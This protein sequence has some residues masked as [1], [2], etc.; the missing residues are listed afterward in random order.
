MRAAAVRLQEGAAG[1]FIARVGGDEFTL[2]VTTGRQPETAV[3]L[4]ERLVAAFQ[5]EFEVDGHRMQVGMS[6]GV[7]IYPADGEDA[8]TLLANADAALYQAKAEM[9]GSVRLFEIELGTRL[10]E[11]REMQNDLRV[12]IQRNQLALHYQPQ[13]RIASNEP[14]GFEALVRWHCPKRGTVSPGTFIPIAEDSGLIIPL[15]EWILR[16]ACEEAAAWPHPLKIAVNISPVQFHRGD[17]A[18]L[19]HEILMETGLS[20][21]RLELEITEGVMIDDFSR[22]VSILHRLKAIG[23]QIAMD[24]FGSGYS[25][26]SYLHA[27]PF[28]KIKI[29]R[30]FI[31]DLEHNHHSM[32]IV[33]AIIPLGHSMAVPILAEGVETEAQREFLLQ[34]GCDEVQGYLTG[35]PQPIEAYAEMVGREPAPARVAA[36]G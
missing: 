23:V 34:E 7:A 25:S 9:R 17:L 33:R 8:R 22:A 13:F 35:K 18:R 16:K 28:D 14:I 30:T 3:E 20:P 32:A 26:L 29:D 21:G 10:R 1:N 19:V 31:G 12:A 5:Q 11:R 36:A 2:V 27:F 24:D 4:G 15:G 6:A